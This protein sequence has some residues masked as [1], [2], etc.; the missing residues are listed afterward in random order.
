MGRVLVA[1]YQVLGVVG[2]LFW[3]MDGFGA[4][5]FEALV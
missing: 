1:R 5:S 3:R 2:D 4:V